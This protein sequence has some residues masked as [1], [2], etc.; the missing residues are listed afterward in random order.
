MPQGWKKGSWSPCDSAGV[1]AGRHT[2]PVCRGR[3]DVELRHVG[4]LSVHDRQRSGRCSEVLQWNDTAMFGDC[5]DRCGLYALAGAFFV[6]M[7]DA[8]DPVLDQGHSGKRDGGEESIRGWSIRSCAAD[9]N[10]NYGMMVGDSPLPVLRV[11]ETRQADWPSV[12]PLLAA[13]VCPG[14]VP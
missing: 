7:S 11:K 5:G 1:P 12:A 14:V 3:W 2:E 10:W 6:A 13:N 4:H 8:P 9:C